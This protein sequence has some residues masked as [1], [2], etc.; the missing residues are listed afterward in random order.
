[1]SAGTP[2]PDTF[3][4]GTDEI[5]VRVGS[6]ET[7]GALFAVEVRM[8]PGGGPP[9]MHR[10]AP[11]ELYQILE[12]EFAF[13]IADD[14][15][16]VLRTTATADEVVPIPGGR[17]HTIRNESDGEARA[18]VVHA[19]GESMERFVRAAAA[20]ATDGAP[21]MDDVLE[22]AAHHGIEV[23]GPIPVPA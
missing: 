23:T 12:G 9:L 11:G 4:V 15:G 16:T 3:R 18:F 19:P 14:V 1:M 13:Y 21:T 8:E 5:T 2:T 17:P 10:H 7:G 20:L 6:A 22:L